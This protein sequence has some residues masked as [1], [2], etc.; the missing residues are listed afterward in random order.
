MNVA[1]ELRAASRWTQSHGEEIANATSHGL[2]FLGA[3]IGAPILLFAAWERGSGPFFIGSVVFAATTMLL[4]L[5]SAVYHFW[6]RTPFKGALQTIDH[7]AIFL[8]DRRH[9]HALRARSAA[10]AARLVDPGN[11]LGDW[12]S[13]ASC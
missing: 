8:L 5:A 4:Y 12:L 11:R 7:S 9:V 3:A 13:S 2:G 10:W 1:D 6:P